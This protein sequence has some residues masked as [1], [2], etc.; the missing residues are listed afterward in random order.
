MTGSACR[1]ALG[2]TALIVVAVAVLDAHDTWLL[3][4]AQRVARGTR[5]D[6]HLTS[7]MTFA[8]DDF[9]IDAARI[10]RA[11]TRLAGTTKPILGRTPK[12]GALF[13]PWTP[14]ASGL[15]TIAV[16]LKP[17]DLELRGGQVEEYFLDINADRDLRALWARIPAPK[18]WRER[19]V[20]HA[21]SYVC[22]EGGAG[23]D[24][25]WARPT[26]LD[27]EIVPERDPTA[28]HVGDSLRV[29]VMHHGAPRAG[30][31]IGAL[32]DGASTP[33]FS[34]T[35][36]AGR[37][38]VRFP[39]AGWWLLHGTLLQRST[40]VSREWDSDFTTATVMILPA[41]AKSG[42]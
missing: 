6:L 38:T 36:A 14:D 40:D 5:V 12:P 4:T 32:K 18:K 29:R 16:S 30:L 27:L 25:S 34:V 11:D 24:S 22:V 33:T 20:K 8:A 23:R 19:Y 37:A 21:L 10:A 41:G 3:P 1:I 13:L 39:S 42:C 28:L 9:V 26:G 31:Q 17:R 7:G 2:A 35:D 15:A